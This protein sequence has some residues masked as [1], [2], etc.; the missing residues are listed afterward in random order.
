M[1]WRWN[2]Y[3]HKELR[4]VAGENILRARQESQGGKKSHLPV[5]KA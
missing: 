2:R 5:I 3:S 4:K 1:L